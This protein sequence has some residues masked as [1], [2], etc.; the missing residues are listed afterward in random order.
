MNGFQSVVLEMHHHPGGLATSW[1]RGDYHFEAGVRVV[2]GTGGESKAHRLW[3]ELGI[4]GV[5]ARSADGSG[6]GF[7]ADP[8]A[9][10]IAS[11]GAEV[12]AR[13]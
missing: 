10:A 7:G 9:S 5:D 8:Y 12:G 6:G 11:V 1:N 13:R 4:D 3:E 2:S